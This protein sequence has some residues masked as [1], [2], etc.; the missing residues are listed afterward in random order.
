M[1][2]SSSNPSSMIAIRHSSG[3]ETLMSISLFMRD[4][5]FLYVRV[6]PPRLLYSVLQRPSQSDGA[7]G[8][9][10]RQPPVAARVSDS[11]GAHTAAQQ[12]ASRRKSDGAMVGG[13]A[14][15]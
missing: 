15:R 1:Y 11:A 10:K 7:R 14:R 6:R 4:N 13:A 12:A 9:H 2:S 5:S 3:C 8:T